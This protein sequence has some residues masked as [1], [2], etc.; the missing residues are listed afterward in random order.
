M[1]HSI[2]LDRLEIPRGNTQKNVNRDILLYLLSAFETSSAFRV[3]DLPSGE[4]EFLRLLRAVYPRASLTGGDL[5]HVEPP[6]SINFRQTDATQPFDFGGN[7]DLVTSISGIMMFGNT[8]LFLENCCRQLASE[9]LIIISNDSC[10]TIRDRLSYLFFGRFRRFKLLIENS[11][12]LTQYIPLQEVCRQ[13]KRNGVEVKDIV[14]TSFYPEDM[15]FLPFAFLLFPFQW[16]HLWRARSTIS[17]SLRF[18]MFPFRSL[19]CR[20][21]F[22]VGQKL[23]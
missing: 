15:L 13:L 4:L 9:G 21:Y 12:G 11:E 20:H 7:F 5:L 1:K 14:Y 17:R 6:A 3:L 23:G 18:R 8:Q 10:F 16:L 19:L 22:V 2:N